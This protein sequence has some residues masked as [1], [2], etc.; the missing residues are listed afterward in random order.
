MESEADDGQTLMTSF[1]ILSTSIDVHSRAI[2]MPAGALSVEVEIVP[3]RLWLTMMSGC[4]GN[5][6]SHHYDVGCSH[7]I[8]A[9]LKARDTEE[10]SRASVTYTFIISY[11]HGS[12]YE[13]SLC[14]H[15]Q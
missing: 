3:L 5:R 11:H 9:L 8:L 14:C 1:G 4:G 7:N 6:W 12:D 2:H 13:S 15:H 10:K